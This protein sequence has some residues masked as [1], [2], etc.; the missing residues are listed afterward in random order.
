MGIQVNLHRALK[1]I[2]NRTKNNQPCYG[3]FIDF[4]NAYNSVPH[5]LLFRKLRT[6]GIFTEEEIQFLEALYSRYT[7]K[8]GK[9]YIRS[10]KGVAQGSIISPALFNIFVE[11]LAETLQKETGIP[12]D[13]L[14]FYA[15]DLLTLS[16]NQN[17]LKKCIQIIEEWSNANGMSLNKKKSAIVTFS[18]RRKRN[19]PDLGCACSEAIQIF[20]HNP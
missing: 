11:D 19:I 4:S 18:G 15:D 1:R 13:D 8:L 12:L 3:L 2:T 16:S 6:K 9:E 20:R 17:Q 5:T 10:N 14:L 7:I